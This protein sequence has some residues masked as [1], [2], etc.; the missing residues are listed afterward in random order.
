[1]WNP[2]YLIIALFRHSIFLLN[3]Y[4]FIYQ[5]LGGG[6]VLSCNCLFI[7]F[8]PQFWQLLLCIFWICIVKYINIPDCIFLLWYSFWSIY[9][10]ILHV[11][12]SIL[13]DQTLRFCS[14]I[15]LVLH[16]PGMSFLYLKKFKDFLYFFL[17]QSVSKTRYWW[18]LFNESNVGGSF[19]NC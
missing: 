13:S 7:Y 4:C 5:F 2:L 18:K 11:L 10:I 19:L 1:M 14:Q 8:F 12:S 16:L 9:N 15:S 17:V 3:F 6:S